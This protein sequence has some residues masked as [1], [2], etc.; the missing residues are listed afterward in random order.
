MTWEDLNNYIKGKTMIEC[1][2]Q[3]AIKRCK[4]N[5][6]RFRKHLSDNWIVLTNTPAKK[7]VFEKDKDEMDMCA[8]YFEATWIYEPPKESAFQKW[9]VSLPSNLVNADR[10][11][12]EGWNAHH[13]AVKKTIQTRGGDTYVIDRADFEE[14]KEP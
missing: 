14:L 2:L 1:T 10:L 8:E 6:G 9:A 12:K 5:G 3:E 4:E 7:A 11:R 13:E